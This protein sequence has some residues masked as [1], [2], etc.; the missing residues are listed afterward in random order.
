MPS[1]STEHRDYRHYGLLRRWSSRYPGWAIFLS[2]TS[3]TGLYLAATIGWDLTQLSTLGRTGWHSH[4]MT[5]WII[6]ERVVEVL[7]FWW[8]VAFGASVGSFLNVV[9]YRMPL[10]MSL[11]AKSSH[12]V[13][14]KYKIRS[15]DNIPVIGW[16]MLRGRCRKCRLPISGRYPLVEAITGIMALIL[17]L[18]TVQM[19]GWGLAPFEG[20]PIPWHFWLMSTAPV[21]PLVWFFF[22]FWLLSVYLAA[23]WINYDRNR[24]PTKLVISTVVAAFAIPALIRLAGQPY[25]ESILP[26]KIAIPFVTHSTPWLLEQLG[27]VMPEAA[28]K[29]ATAQLYPIWIQQ[30][31][32]GV[33]GAVGGLVFWV[34]SLSAFPASAVAQASNEL[35]GATE[36][37]EASDGAPDDEGNSWPPAWLES[38]CLFSLA[39]FFSGPW[40]AGLVILIDFLIVIVATPLLLNSRL[41]PLKTRWFLLPYA[42]LLAVAVWRFS[43]AMLIP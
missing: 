30:L 28:G 29:N 43:E 5:E 35:G 16:L 8:V 31:T 12:C 34:I 19:R 11:S 23:A 33:V 37:A 20:L 7:L 9:V 24:L 21:G 32:G 15:R 36:V 27:W 25:L 13:W 3:L 6:K 39:G 42:M 17:F 4:G 38:V 14:C 1:L 26:G 2:I 18:L 22:L 10:G 40:F 41:S